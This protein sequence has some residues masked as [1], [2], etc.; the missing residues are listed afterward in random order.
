MVPRILLGFRY[1]N[2]LRAERVHVLY[3]RLRL[4]GYGTPNSIVMLLPHWSRAY[5][6]T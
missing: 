2:R 4:H 1:L 6:H 3:L 5:A